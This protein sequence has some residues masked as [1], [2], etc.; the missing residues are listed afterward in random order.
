MFENDIGMTLQNIAKKLSLLWHVTW[1]KEENFKSS[2]YQFFFVKPTD[3]LKLQFN[4][5]RELLVLVSLFQTFDARSLDFVDRLMVDY[6]NRLDKICFIIVS[7]D[8]D[9]KHK[10]DRQINQD[11]EVRIIVPYT[12]EEVLKTTDKE[13]FLKRLRDCFSVRD[14]FDF[15]APLK[16]DLFFF[17]R[18]ELIHNLY[19]RYSNGENSGLFGLRKIGKTSA[20]YALGRL[21]K[22]HNEPFVLIQCD[23][24]SFYLSDW[25]KALGY[26]IVKICEQV[27]PEGRKKLIYERD[28]EGYDPDK[29]SI[30][31]EQDL[32]Y[33]YNKNNKKKLLLVF[34]EI[35]NLT[36]LS[37][38]REW[39]KKS[40]YIFFWQAIRSSYQANP[41]L[42]SIVL[43]GRNPS[44]LETSKIEKTVN[45]L[46]RFVNSQYMNFF[47]IE[48][49]EEMV[50]FIGNYMGLTFDRQIYTYLADDFGGHPLFVRLICSKL[51]K[52]AEKKRPCNISRF[53]YKEHI[54]ELIHHVFADVGE[55][56]TD[57]QYSYPY[58]YDLLQYLAIGDISFFEECAKEMPES[59][60]H[61]EG[62][63]II[64]SSH[65][66]YYF[67]IQAIKRYLEGRTKLK[68]AGLSLEDKWAELNSIRNRI[69]FDLRKLIEQNLT[70][71]LGK[72][73]GKKR[74]IASIPKLAKAKYRDYDFSDFLSKKRGEIVLY[75]S[76]LIN[77]IYENWEYFSNVFPDKEDFKYNMKQA[78][79][80]RRADAHATDIADDDFEEARRCYQWL[81][82]HISVFI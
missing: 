56:L 80:Y 63:G 61:L 65:G 6:T 23:N 44:F 45:P 60:E 71:H 35:E 40:H 13:I 30:S 3:Q 9:I 52:I 75:F 22:L 11:K 59:I 78:N 25:N 70:V 58:E 8:L 21:L 57:L 43:T 50:T 64:K 49:I 10:I 37:P 16:K 12:M 33:I 41:A 18:S 66:K 2:R 54:E 76:D 29:A 77:V 74:L 82:K 7:K 69:E 27:Y 17:G 51:H 26:L 1:V 81:D 36:L 15:T 4:L 72:E 20:L 53:L 62:Y 55:I 48:Q 31:F 14:L 68:K 24:P 34:D 47:D 46:Y 67:T 42:F 32:L 19:S 28:R 38:N 39:I 5:D 73:N 79:K